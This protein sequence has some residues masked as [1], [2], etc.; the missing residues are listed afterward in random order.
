MSSNDPLVLEEEIGSNKEIPLWKWVTL[1][2]NSESFDIDCGRV[3]CRYATADF[4]ATAD[5]DTVVVVPATFR[6]ASEMI[7]HVIVAN[8]SGSDV[9]I[10][11]RR[12]LV[13]C[14]RP[15]RFAYI[16]SRHYDVMGV[17]DTFTFVHRDDTLCDCSHFA[18]AASDT[19]DINSVLI[20]SPVTL[21]DCSAATVTS[22]GHDAQT[23]AAVKLSSFISSLMDMRSSATQCSVC[24]IP[25]NYRQVLEHLTKNID[26]LSVVYSNINRERMK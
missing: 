12:P 20:S 4:M 26:H 3:R 14:I 1:T 7:A 24:R 22:S 25:S 6:F 9:D 18:A 17:S 8:C 5:A 15:Y 16:D 23:I 21:P 19:D 13:R 11:I 2:S 10:I